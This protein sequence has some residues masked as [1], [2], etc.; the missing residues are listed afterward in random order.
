MNAVHRH[1]DADERRARLG[2]RHLLAPSHHA[3]AMPDV[4]QAL[5]GLH[6]TDPSTVFLAAAA[7]TSA[8]DIAAMEEA[9]YEERTLERMLCMRRTMFV[10]P[11]ATAPVIEASTGRAIAAKER[12][13]CAVYLRDGAGWSAQRYAAVEEDLLEALAAR[14]APPSSPPTYPHYGSR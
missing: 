12:A 13:A 14:P 8:P 7:R 3:A 1:V 2:I 6:A 11:A 4:A 5:V 10:V 9:L